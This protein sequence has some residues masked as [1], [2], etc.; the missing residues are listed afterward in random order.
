VLPSSLGQ[1]AV[2]AW[3]ALRRPRGAADTIAIIFVDRVCGL[4]GLAALILA[5][6][7]LLARLAG[8]RQS[9]DVAMIAAAFAL[10]AF[11]GAVCVRVVSPPR[12]WPPFLKKC[13][14]AARHAS[15]LLTSRAGLVAIA[16]SIGAQLLV[17]QSIWLIAVSIGA[18]LSLTEGFAT[19]PPAVFISVMPISINGWGVREGAMV[20]SLGFAGVAASDA[21]LISVL[22]G[23]ALLAT[24]LPGILALLLLKRKSW[25]TPQPAR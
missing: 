5:G 11:V 14:D 2:R 16:I 9:G 3:L 10:A 24:S 20:V 1:D 4:L 23:C 15:M 13:F 18:P 21:L 19:I 6:L 12:S 22:F 17:L 7:P 8:S 25:T